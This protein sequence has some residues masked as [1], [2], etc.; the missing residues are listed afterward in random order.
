MDD[1]ALAMPK[2]ITQLIPQMKTTMKFNSRTSVASVSGVAAVKVFSANG[3]YDPDITGV[4]HQPRGFDQLMALYDHYVVIASKITV[5]F[6]NDDAS[7]N[8]AIPFVAVLDR[9]TANTDPRDYLESANVCYRAIS[10]N[11]DN[12]HCLVSQINPNKFLGRSK[13]MAD[14]DLKGS[15]GSNP[16][17]QVY[18]HVGA[19][20]IQ[21][22]S[23]TVFINVVIEYTAILIEPTIPPLS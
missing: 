2:T 12:C 16:D 10:E 8:A 9:A 6:Q 4:G 13:P 21:D 11:G 20:G 15:T 18:F 23:V 14:P 7:A 1:V 19:V 3:M 22:T 17:E 5:W